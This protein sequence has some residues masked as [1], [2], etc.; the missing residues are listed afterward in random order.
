M[1]VLYVYNDREKYM[2]IKDLKN[3]VTIVQESSFSQ[4]SKRLFVSQPALSQSVKRLEAELGVPLFYRD[5]S[6]A[7]PTEAGMLLATKGEPLVLSL[8]A[9]DREVRQLGK[10]ENRIVTLGM[11]QFY[12]HHMLS[13]ALKSFGEYNEGIHL[14]IVE[15]ESYF[16]ENQIKMGRLDFG[17][18]PSPI[19]SSSLE[20]IPIV[21]EEILLVINE[22]NK[23]AME[24]AVSLEAK[25]QEIPIESFAKFPFILLKP[26][27]KL[28]SLVDAICLEHHFRPKA[29]FESENLDT[30]YS[31][32]RDNYGITFL[33]NTIRHN[34]PSDGIR[35]FHVDTR[36]SRRDL[37][38]VSMPDVAEKLQ[39]AQVAKH[40]GKAL[41]RP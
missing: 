39:L 3:I 20:C 41:Q 4:A 26:E 2:D 11:S 29:I 23:E 24:L 15:G 21:E 34:K 13:K 19:Y 37:V 8:E 1:Q 25:K 40:I 14:Q 17:I 7:L 30:C 9:L 32:V 33:P 10:P 22:N 5:R 12:G 36:L 18:F 31:L 6:R 28:R 35:F 16:L 38:L 27:L